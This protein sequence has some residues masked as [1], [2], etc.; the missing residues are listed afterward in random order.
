MSNSSWSFYNKQ[1]TKFGHYGGDRLVSSRHFPEEDPEQRFEEIVVQLGASERTLLDIGSG[2]GGFTLSLAP[3]YGQIIGIEPSNLIQTAMERQQ[4]AG[5]DNVDF[6]RQDGFQTSFADASFDV[7]FSRRGPNP[8]PEV[9]RL[10]KTGGHFVHIGIGYED[11]RDLKDLFGRGQMFNKRGSSLNW[12]RTNLGERGYHIHLLKD[13][14][15]DEYYATF[16][17][18]D[19]FLFRV[20]IF[21]EYGSDE[22]RALLKQYADTHTTPEGIWLGRH[23]YLIHA[24]KQ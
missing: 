11:T 9:D 15:Y 5:I 8:R 21:E 6:Q 1:H 16:D 12:Q 24:E 7:I 3:H 13:Y 22:D 17:D 18:L 2:S 20:P 4:D 23:R 14:I 10:L 19:A